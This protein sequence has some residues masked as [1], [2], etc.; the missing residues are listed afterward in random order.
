M[1]RTRSCEPGIVRS[2]QSLSDP[3][4]GVDQLV[5]TSPP[6]DAF[7]AAEQDEMDDDPNADGDVEMIA[8]DDKVFFQIIWSS[9]R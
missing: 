7:A 5:P 6:A 9:M 4:L 3:D 1:L 2:Q 8:E